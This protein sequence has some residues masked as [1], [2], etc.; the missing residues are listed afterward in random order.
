M[1]TPVV[2]VV[3]AVV[4]VVAVAVVAVVVVAVVIV[5]IVAVVVVAVIAVVVV[6]RFSDNRWGLPTATTAAIT[7]TPAKAT[8]QQQ[9]RQ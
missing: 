1:L 4:A 2:V 3:V 5:V 8:L 6:A 9:Q 7:A